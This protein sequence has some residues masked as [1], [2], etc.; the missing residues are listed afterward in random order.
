LVEPSRVTFFRPESLLS[1]QQSWLGSIQVMQPVGLRWLIFGVLAALIAAGT[2]LFFGEYTRKARL[3]GV[4]V[5]DRGLIRIVPPVASASVLSMTMREGQVVRAGDVLATLQVEEPSLNPASQL[6]LQQTFDARTRSLDEAARQTVVLKDARERALVERIEAL[7]REMAPLDAQAAL[8]QQR[9]T[10]SEQALARVESLGREHFVSSAQVQAKEGELLG[11]KA[12]SAAIARQRQT[13]QREWTG[14]EADRRE[15]PLQAQQR[16]GEIERDRAAITEA[17]TR[18][19]GQ[20][21]THQL[22]VRAP[23]DGVVTALL[24]EVGQSVTKDAAMASLMPAGARLQAQLYAPSSALG[25]IQ[26]GQRVLLRLQAFPYQKYGLQPAQVLQ[27]A[28]APLQS[29][30]VAML[31][32]A[33]K[34]ANGEPLYRV[35]VTVD[36]QQVMVGA[37]ARPMLAGMQVDADVLLEK[38]RLIE[39][40]F[41]P[42]LGWARRV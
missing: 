38:R 24:A 13:L 8:L 40:L 15:L 30:E 17:T 31:P 20:A 2:L 32:L 39:W 23:A 41:E 36:R 28:Q 11:L 18:S 12:E 3:T 5:P 6:G 42:L 19:A 10:L 7:R 26:P 14:L 34:P 29:A 27:V 16:L 25:F 37:Q 4:L 35:T 22:L 33:T 1:R 9:L 21:A